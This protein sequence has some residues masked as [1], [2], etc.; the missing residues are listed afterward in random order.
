MT[1]KTYLGLNPFPKNKEARLV[2]LT[3]ELLEII[4]RRLVLKNTD[5]DFLF[6]V[7]GKPLNYGTIQVNYRAAQKET[8]IKYSGSHFLRHS[9][10]TLGRQVGGSLDAV[11]SM[12]G[13]KDYKLADH[14]SKTSQSLQKETSIKIMDHIKSLNLDEEQN[15][16]NVV[17]LRRSMT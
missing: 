2:Y 8:G 14:Y 7:D 11:M 12:T 17:Q 6:H 4:E 13:H 10:A 16:D 9:M 15:F 1:K 3:D 5:S